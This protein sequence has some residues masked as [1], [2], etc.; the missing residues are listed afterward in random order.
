MKPNSSFLRLLEIEDRKKAEA[1]KGGLQPVRLADVPIPGGTTVVDSYHQEATSGTTGRTDT[2]STTTTMDRTATS[3]TSGSWSRPN[4]EQVNLKI[5]RHLAE[6][7]KMWCYLN[8]RSQSQAFCDAVNILMGSGGTTDRTATCGSG[9]RSATTL[10]IDDLLID[11]I[12]SHYEA[13]T[14]NKASAADRQTLSEMQNQHPDHNR[15]GI[16][17]SVLRSKSRINS[18]RYCLGAIEEAAQMPPAQAREY[19]G[20]LRQKVDQRKSQH[21]EREGK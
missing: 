21:P 17:L 14:G 5:P 9:G 12:I 15:V 20:Y 10:L 11:D 3:S 8:R 6:K 4:L 7:F 18:L 13:L 16:L 19:I 1:E 2:T